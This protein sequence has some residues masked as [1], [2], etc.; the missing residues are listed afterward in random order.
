MTEELDTIPEAVI[1][2]GREAVELYL[3]ILQNGETV[4]WATMCALQQPPGTK[5]TDRAFSQGQAQKMERMPKRNRDQI[6]AIAKKAGIPTD[7]KF[8]VGALGKYD[9]PAAWVTSAEDVI[10]S[11]KVQKI[12]VEGVLNYEPP[13]KKQEI[14]PPKSVPLAPELVSELS[15]K[16]MKAD[17]ALAEKCRKDKRARQA[18]REKVIAVHGKQP[19]R[20]TAGKGF[21]RA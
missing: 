16:A 3:Q 12:G 11:C 20:A 6:M 19:K 7:G 15:R 14:A 9:N 1:Q 5:N 18:L 17:P 21:R 8:Y 13:S 4:R 2:R 10:T